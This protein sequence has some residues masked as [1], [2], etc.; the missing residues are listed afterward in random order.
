MSRRKGGLRDKCASLSTTAGRILSPLDSGGIRPHPF[1]PNRT[2]VRR[3]AFWRGSRGNGLSSSA[4]EKV[5]FHHSA[6]RAA[7]PCPVW[8]DYDFILQERKRGLCTTGGTPP[9][10]SR[11]IGSVSA[12]CAPPGPSQ[13]IV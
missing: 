4:L 8:I 3:G 11:G 13:R 7:L 5:M 9:S 6:I 1:A 10:R 12:R 2:S